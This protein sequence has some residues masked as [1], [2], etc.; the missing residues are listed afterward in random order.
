MERTDDAELIALGGEL[1]RARRRYRRLRK[2]RADRWGAWSAAIEET[3][4]IARRI[5]RLQPDDLP[6]LLICYQALHWLLLE[7]DDVIMDEEGRHAFHAFGGA[8]RQ[9]ARE[10]DR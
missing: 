3:T 1:T 9:L 6:G 10:Q 2:D 8:V 4:T 5:G 7:Q